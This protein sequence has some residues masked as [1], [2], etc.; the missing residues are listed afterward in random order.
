MKNKQNN[1]F[2]VGFDP[3]EDEYDT[4]PVT[5][6]ILR[7][8]TPKVEQTPRQPRAPPKKPHESSWENVILSSYAARRAAERPP[9]RRNEYQPVE[10]LD[11]PTEQAITYHH[12]T[13]GPSNKPTKHDDT[14]AQLARLKFEL[15]ASTNPFNPQRHGKLVA[16]LREIIHYQQGELEKVSTDDDTEIDRQKRYP[17]LLESLLRKTLRSGERNGVEVESL[18]PEPQ[19]GERFGL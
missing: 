1:T 17:G 7:K 9:R 2:Y 3:E 11:D 16:D 14:Q 8:T 19:P 13:P 18:L 5:P 4:D 10:T 15:K 6:T 12:T